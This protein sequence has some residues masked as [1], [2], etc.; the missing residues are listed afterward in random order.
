MIKRFNYLLFATLWLLSTPLQAQQFFFSSEQPGVCGGADGIITI[1]PTRGVPPFT[2]QWSNGETSISIRNIPKGVYEATLTDATGATVAHTFYLNSEALDL[3]KTASLPAGGCNVNSGA[4]SI[5]VIGGIAPYNI[6][7]S[8]GQTGASIQNLAAG[9]YNVTITDAAGCSA[10]SVF[11]VNSITPGSYYPS[12][13]I[14]VIEKP[15][16]AVPT[17]GELKA[18]M[19]YSGYPPYTYQWSNGANTQHIDNLAEGAY[20]VTITDALGCSSV[21]ED[22]TLNKKL[23]GTGNV[24][25]D[26]STT[27]TATAQLVNGTA[28]VTYL[29][30]NGQTGPSLN[31]LANGTYFVTATDANGCSATEPVTVRIPYL[32]FNDYSQKCFSGNEGQGYVWVNYDQGLTF[33]WD[34]GVNTFWNSSLSAG[35]HSVTVTTELGC[36]LTGQMQIAP[37][38]AP[39]ITIA[40]TTTAADCSQSLSGGIN[41]TINGG[42]QPYNFYAY[43]PGGTIADDPSDLQ[44]VQGGTYYLYVSSLSAYCNTSVEVTVPDQSGFEP[45]ILSNYQVDCSTGFGSAAII[46]ADVPNVQY[47]WSHGATDPA[48]FNLTDG[49]YSVTVSAGGSCLRYFNLCF[50]KDS[51]E[52]DPCFAKASGRLINDQGAAGCAGTSGIPYQVIQA[53]P[54]GAYYFTD[55]NGDYTVGLGFGMNDLTPAQYNQADIACPPGA[56][57]QVNATSGVQISG[58]DFHYLSNSSIDHRVRQRPLRT[59]QPGYPYS[60][61]LEVC[62]DGASVNPG[63]LDIEFANLFG[64]A[65]GNFFAQHPGALLLD[66]ETSGAPNNHATFSFPGVDQGACELLQLDLLTPTTAA[67]GSE[68]EINAWVSPNAGDPT[69]ANNRSEQHSSVTGAF[70]P[71]AVYAYP[72]RN[73]NPKDGGEIIRYQDNTIVYQIFFQNTGTAPADL[74]VV[75]DTLDEQLNL[76]SIRNITSSHHMKI[77][78]NQE[79]KELVFRFENI[80]LPDSTSDYAG[81]IGSIQYEIDLKPGVALGT[82]IKKQAAIYFDFNTPVIT[83]Q[84]VL[85]VVNSSKVAQLLPGNQIILFPNPAGAFVGFYSDGTSDVK[86]FDSFGRLM[87]TGQ[88]ENGL[89]QISSIDW[90]SGVYFVQME[91]Q[92]TLK[93]GKVVVQH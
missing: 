71:N 3:R 4:L 42:L 24:V 1:V 69:P 40:T 32:T 64:A 19:F 44:Q 36:T 68:Y 91:T 58:L 88:F 92:G 79:G 16:C 22:F 70:D 62:N 63:T 81:S 65:T 83:N 61:R 52:T 66:N 57:H 10:Q 84:N 28:P 80:A 59:A 47:Q 53:M 27:G 15:N 49:C 9:D 26:G 86:V 56:T 17:A 51:L 55:E 76:A 41:V 74:V 30:S 31:N 38:I 73:G 5:E 7:W 54:S 14:T 35:Q 87:H 75:R 34:N 45:E 18:Q 46:N 85:E 90:P 60:L 37:P 2:Y 20:S 12:A 78:T 13:D 23:I 6:A 11:T 50:V 29:W 39:P 72:A 77:T 82:E 43:G 25:C 8:N 93:T 21:Y 67:L 48:L 89:Q 33:Q